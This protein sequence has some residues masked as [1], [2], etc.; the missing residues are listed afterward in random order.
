MNITLM[1]TISIRLVQSKR[2]DNGTYCSVLV[3]CVIQ[4]ENW[5]RINNICVPLFTNYSY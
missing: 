4:T 1:C 2:G 3:Q 5:S